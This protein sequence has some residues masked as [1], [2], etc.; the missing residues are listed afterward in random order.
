MDKR[1]KEYLKHLDRE[2]AR[3]RTTEHTHRPAL[4]AF[5]ES[6]ADVLATNEPGRVKCGAPDFIVTKAGPFIIGYIETKDIGKS[7]DAA[8]DSEQLMR[9]RASLGNLILTDY[10][11]FRW[12]VNGGPVQTAVLSEGLD[13]GRLKRD[14]VGAK[15]VLQLFTDFLRYKPEPLSSPKELA[16]RMARV[17]HFIRD[18][19]VRAF[20]TGEASKSLK[21]LRQ[22]FAQT[23]IPDLDLPHK[24][25][26]FADMYAQT[27]AY[28]LFAARCNH[29]PTR[30]FKRSEAAAEIPKTNPF[31]R[32]I[33]ETIAG[34][35]LSDEPYVAF[36]DELVQL[37]AFADI[38]A[39]L[40]NFGKRTKQE[41]PVV[42]FYETFL[43]SYDPQLR[44]QRGVYY[45]PEPVVLYIV[46]SIDKLL[47]SRFEVP[48]GLSD[49]ATVSYERPAHKGKTETVTVPKV[50]VLDPACGT[51]TFLYYVIDHIREDFMAKGNAGLWATYIENQLL[52]RLYGFELLMAPYAVAHFKLALQLA[53]QDL[54]DA[55]R[56][57][58]AYNF[59]KDDRLAV[60]L[61]N[62][63]EEI[64]HAPPT[65][66]GPLRVITEE[67]QAADHVKRVMPILVVLGN[68]PYSGQSANRSWKTDATGKREPTFVGQL[69]RDYYFVDGRPLG[70]RNPKWLQDD[71]VKFVRWGQWRIE[72]SGAGILAVIT[73]HGYLDNPT[74]RGMRQSLMKSFTD[75]FIYNLH[76]NSKKKELAPDGLLDKNIFDI[77]QGVAVGLFVKQPGR[78]PPATV[79]HADLWGS[80]RERKYK[81]LLG[82]DVDSTEWM[83]LSPK[84]PL[85]L[86]VPVDTKLE[87]EY[88]RG[89]QVSKLF[90][91]QSNGIVTARDSLTIHFTPEEV[92]TVVH[93]F[94]KLDPKEAMQKY[95]IHDSKEWTVK[96]A[97][98]DLKKSGPKKQNVVPVQYRPFDRRYTYYTGEIG[99]IGRPRPDIMQHMLD[100]ENI[101]LHVCRQVVSDMYRHA[102]ATHLITDDCYVSNITR[103]RGF[104]MPLYVTPGGF[105]F[106]SWPTNAAGQ[107]PNFEPAA[108]ADIEG[109]LRAKFTPRPSKDKTFT[110]EELLGYIYALLY[111]ETFRQ[112]YNQFLKQDFPKIPVTS[113]FQLFKRLATCG[114]RLVQLHTMRATDLSIDSVSYPVPGDHLVARRYPWFTDSDPASGKPLPEPRVYLNE[115]QYFQ[116]VPGPA[117]EFEIGSYQPC[118]KWL[119]DRKN[120]KLS[121]DELNTYRAL[122]VSVQETMQLMDKIDDIIPKWPLP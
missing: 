8:E 60:Y 67:A 42:H 46:R 99:F 31:L 106:S 111:S 43:A 39:I 62:T 116:N 117:W 11:R 103:E 15:D 65:L 16:E 33:F 29:P 86:F 84:A 93:D 102:L 55:Q 58:W 4:K 96:D 91:V 57:K 112:R 113:D 63:L 75:I 120:R 104:T 119:K 85:Y 54:S 28:G 90:D 105:N 10:L 88:H 76:G 122:V 97:L 44:E 52:P 23:L 70:E 1:V 82:Q 72:R 20:E 22:A 2:L 59:S 49:R 98:A 34:T 71:Y 92:W 9:Y 32:R 13:Q 77:R 30:E 94:V 6:L 5:V 38:G 89:V 74:F 66:Y 73:N 107:V 26:E 47:R 101:A 18:I 17:T 21:D 100:H 53:G 121:F 51:G 56:E 48:D 81:H 69:V 109:K 79:H 27:I 78:T 45:T 40:K 115:K 50:L 108:I 118:E 35:E 80:S 24:A 83:T 12:Y 36:V 25:A 68:P 19:I 3:S 41:D 7:L 64:E 14:P 114:L 110:P 61:T 37:L 95:G 87:A